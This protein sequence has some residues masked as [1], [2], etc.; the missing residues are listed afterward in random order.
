MLKNKIILAIKLKDVVF[1]L[2]INDK[3]P[4]IGILTFNEQDK[5][6]AQLS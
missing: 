2:L 5:L 1:I 6:L 4:T 3:M